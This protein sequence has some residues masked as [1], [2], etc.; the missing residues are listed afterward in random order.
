M[1]VIRGRAA[2]KGSERREQTFTGMVWLDPVLSAE[3]LVVNNVF[4]EPGAHS[5]WHHH[6][7]GQLLIFTHGAGYV[8]NREGEVCAVRAGDVVYTPAG[9]VHWH[10]AGPDTYMHHLAVSLGST[11][12]LEEVSAEHYRSACDQGRD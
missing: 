12:W 10:G 5:Y 11:V 7:V 8:T 4:F 3:G 1:Q 9:E 6:E 2:G